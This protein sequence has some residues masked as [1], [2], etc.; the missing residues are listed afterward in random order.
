M[1]YGYENNRQLQYE[2]AVGAG[3][4]IEHENDPLNSMHK[5]LKKQGGEGSSILQGVEIFGEVFSRTKAAIVYP[6]LMGELD[7]SLIIRTFGSCQLG[8]PK[9]SD[10]VHRILSDCDGS[11][12]DTL[13]LN[14]EMNQQSAILHRSCSHNL[15]LIRYPYLSKDLGVAAGELEIEDLMESESD[16]DR[17]EDIL[18][19]HDL[20]TKRYLVT[21]SSN[22]LSNTY[23]PEDLMQLSPSNFKQLTRTTHI[24]FG[25]LCDLLRGDSIFYNNS[26]HKQIALEIQLAVGLSR[27]GSNGNGA[28]IGKIQMIFG[29]GEGTVVLYTKRVIQAIHNL[30]DYK[31][32]WPSKEERKESS[33]VMQLEGFPNCVGFVD[34]TSLP[35]SQKPALDGNVYFDLVMILMSFSKCVFGLNKEDYFDEGE[36][37]LADSA[38]A[39][40]EVVVP[41]Y[42]VSTCTTDEK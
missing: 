23:S 11:I 24:A 35:L 3:E 7:G 40:S 18:L 5:S 10:L 38:Y 9:R 21:R 31:V 42:W 39:S 30:K 6:V 26:R 36:Y 29:V 41:A 17:E 1:I 13:L 33:Q 37:I 16:S 28:S 22:K 19:L 32:K 8:T 2:K 34:G 12:G 4:G 15:T 20:Y 27:L 14:L 25:K